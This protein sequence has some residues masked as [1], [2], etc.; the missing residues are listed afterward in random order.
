MPNS[1]TYLG[2]VQDVQ[3]A[4]I[5]IALDKD[6]VSGLAFIDGHGYR[7][8]Q[9][10]SFV[11]V[12]IG[13]TDLFGIV[14]QVGAGAVPESLAQIE[15][16]GYR[17]MKVQLVGEGHRSGEFK[18]GISQ[19]PTIGDNAHL[20]TEQDL[21]SI[22]G[23]GEPDDFVSV[24]HLASTEAIPAL[25]NINTLITR[26]AA[27]VGTTGSGKSTTV[28]GLLTSLAD[29]NRY[30]SARILVLDIH[31]E[32]GKA[33]ADCST[34][35]RVT[36][37]DE[38]KGER[39]L[40]IPFWALSFDE[41]IKV[42]F[43]G[44]DGQKA[45]T[46]TDSVL[47][48][49]RESL[50]QSP[51]EGVT[52][53][54]VTVDSPVPFCVHKL[55]LELHK[56]EHLTVVPKPGG[57]AGELEPAYV[58]DSSG[59]PEQT[60]DAMSVTP[61]A[62]RTVKTT[63]P[64]EERVQHGTG[65]I[66]IRQQLASL[67]SK[68]RDPRFGFLFNPGDWLP[69]VEGKTVKDLDALLQDW[70]G[71]DSPITIL[72]LSG[73]PSAVLNDLVGALL[74]IIYDALFWARKLPEGGR[75]RPLLVV[76]EEAHAYLSADSSEAASMAV[77]RIAKEGRKYGVGL[78][79]VSQ[80]PSEIDSTI[81]SQCGTICAMRL[82]NET[83]RGHVTSAASDSLKGL[84]DML[85]VLRTGEAIIVGEAVSLPIRT[86]IDPPAKNRKP[87]SEDPRVVVRGSLQ[88]DG[89]DGAGGWNQ[90][91]DVPDYGAVVRLWRKQSPHY[92]HKKAPPN[93]VNPPQN[94]KE[95]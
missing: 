39:P 37:A 18:R 61:P 19:Y 66:G 85:P 25:V 50:T 86:L 76:L 6:T 23:P 52:K 74:R 17:W 11:R 90:K 32:Y 57:S 56:R 82:A 59:Q 42:G 44:L 38:D 93:T 22:Y 89:F 31:G 8:G 72:D 83:D 15:P 20:V 2:T 60:G 75:E 16:Y 40:H 24:G 21:R 64:A 46:L 84:F 13:F 51:C 79:L 67:A 78:M 27:V 34:V 7:I 65:G 4:T 26:H 48:L 55:W 63:G 35:F 91:R 80:R 28:A 5:S 73:I 88:L 45:A 95:T 3:G 9:I 87:D 81:L 62:Y 71:G 77:R 47:L 54:T 33:L 43:G 49:K 68:L 14:S 53:E 36:A 1:P 30:P 12:S 69:D 41:L 58:L 92:E 94:D 70:I 10:G 29:S